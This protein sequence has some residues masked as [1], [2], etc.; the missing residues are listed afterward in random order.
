MIA[1]KY[2]SNGTSLIIHLLY[3]QMVVYFNIWL[4]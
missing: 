4:S 1:N 3:Y 2:Y